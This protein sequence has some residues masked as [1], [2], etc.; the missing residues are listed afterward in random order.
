M[1]TFYVRLSDETSGFEVIQRKEMGK[2]KSVRIQKQK[3][4][5][6]HLLCLPFSRKT[7]IYFLL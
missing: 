1:E 2:N 7:I 3:P 6:V 5:S 4:F